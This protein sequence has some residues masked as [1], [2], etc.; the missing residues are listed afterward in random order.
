[1]RLKGKVAIVTGAAMGVRGDLMGIGGA[2]AW[3]FAE[4]G[5][6]L[7]LTDMNAEKG[8]KTAAQIRES[9]AEAV[10]VKHEIASD[11]DW[12]RVVQVA[13]ERFDTV[14]VLVNCA[15]TT[16]GSSVETTTVEMWDRMMDIHAKGAFL[17]MK[18]CIPI[19][20]AAGGGAVVILSSTDG[21]IGGGFSAPYASA[22]GANRLLARAAA[23]QYAKDNI[24]V[25]SLHPGEIDTPLSRWAVDQ[26]LDSGGA[27]PR[28]DWVPMGR[29]GTAHEVAQSILFL[30]SDESA[31]MTGAELVIDGGIIAK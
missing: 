21:M 12:K 14:N 25:N 26:V 11:A 10:F 23:I 24:R 19:M 22:K 17:G 6:R 5:A 31:Y 18:H 8:E 13:V 29:L 15:G 9:G 20:R 30:A 16:V 7:V 28:L 4:E 3:L 2:T 1:M 27:D